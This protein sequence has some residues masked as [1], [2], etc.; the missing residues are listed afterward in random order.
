MLL[1]A[2]HAIVTEQIERLRTLADS[3]R[4][5][6]DGLYAEVRQVERLLDE[7]TLQARV[8]SERGLAQRADFAAREQQLRTNHEQLARTHQALVGGLKQLDQL[9]RQIEM[10][11]T[12]L[13]GSDDAEPADPWIQALRS[14]II[15]GREEERVRLAREVH[16]GP[17]QVLANTLMG[18]EH[19]RS[20]LAEQRLDRLALALDRMRDTTREGLHEVRQFI[21]NLRPGRLTDQGLVGALH[22]YIR[23]FHDAYGS[24]VLFEADPLPRLATEVE[25]VLYRIVQEAIQNAHKHARGATVHV[26][27]TVR[28]GNLALTIRDDGPGFNPREV[29]RRAGR[30]N[31]GLSSMRERAE[32]IGARFVVSSSPGHG[33]EVAVTFP[34]Q[35]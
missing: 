18:L 32:L 34:L 29:A 7:A 31:W 3:T 30:E 26:V 19:S 1:E 4:Q 15:M 13:R 35:F 12:T 9:V 33:T 28:T 5:R 24:K 11:S 21:A 20:L 22:D 8:A 17:A 25:V 27:L 6:A 14:Q 2:A 23:R 10:S 16:D